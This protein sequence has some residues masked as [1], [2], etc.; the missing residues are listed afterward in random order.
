MLVLTVCPLCLP[1]QSPLLLPP[2]VAC[3]E[4]APC[5]PVN[6]ALAALLLPAMLPASL[7]DVVRDHVNRLEPPALVGVS[8]TLRFPMQFGVVSPPEV[9]RIFF[10]ES[11]EIEVVFVE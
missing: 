8:S 2:P 3:L 11:K 4:N 10:G 9:Q 5:L 6:I 1:V 7:S